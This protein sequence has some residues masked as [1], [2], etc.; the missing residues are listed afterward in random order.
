MKGYAAHERAVFEPVTQLRTEAMAEH[1]AARRA[2]AGEQALGQGVAQLLAVAESYPDLKAS[3]H[4]L[5]LQRELVDT[6]DRIQVARR[7]YN[8]NVRAY[9]SLVQTFPSLLV[10]RHASTSAPSRTSRWSRRSATRDRPRSTCP[11][12]AQSG[13][14]TVTHISLQITPPLGAAIRLPEVRLLG[15]RTFSTRMNTLR[16]GSANHV[17][18]RPATSAMPST[19]KVTPCASSS[20]RRRG[21]VV[22][23]QRNVRE[24]V[25]DHRRVGRP[26]ASL[27]VRVL[28]DLDDAV[29]V[30]GH[31]DDRGLHHHRRR[32]ELAH[33]ALDVGPLH[34]VRR[35]QHGEAEH[36]AVPGDRG[37]D[38]GDAQRGVREAGDHAATPVGSIAAEHTSGALVPSGRLDLHFTP[39]Q[40]RFRADA[41]GVAHRSPRRCR[42]PRC[43]GRGGPGD[44]HECFDERWEWEQELGA[45]PDGSAS[46]GPPSTAAAARRSSS[47]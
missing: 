24:A 12:Q 43:A 36:V 46:V 11:G 38:V 44:E 40:E 14:P 16:H 28:D 23:E 25:V 33:V 39:A 20:A 19:R 30:V 26:V 34:A 29:G 3:E 2:G 13:G 7:I 42:S 47:R 31:A 6:E 5:A 22:A 4:F 45:R 35:R 9:D 18:R 10:A 17:V 27:R 21:H 1:G 8:A 37:L 41:R 15:R 32:H